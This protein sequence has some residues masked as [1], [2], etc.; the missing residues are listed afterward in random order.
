MDEPREKGVINLVMRS[1]SE[2]GIITR[3]ACEFYEIL[4][5][6][7][8]F[9]RITDAADLRKRSLMP[10][11]SC[12]IQNTA[13]VGP[14]VWSNTRA[15]IQPIVIAAFNLNAPFFFAGIGMILRGKE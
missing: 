8:A 3:I 1:F 2:W 13:N 15:D 6:E 10:N 5:P 4:L 12:N 14:K 7:P 11:I 9:D